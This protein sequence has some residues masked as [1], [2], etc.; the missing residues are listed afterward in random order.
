MTPDNKRSLGLRSDE[1]K[2]LKI[3]HNVQ[4]KH[5]LVHYMIDFIM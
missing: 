5:T 3:K 4:V 2:I 1:L